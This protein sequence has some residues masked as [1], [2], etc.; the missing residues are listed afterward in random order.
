MGK[1][2]YIVELP[3]VGVNVANYGDMPRCGWTV[4][5]SPRRAVRNFLRRSNGHTAEIVYGQ[6]EAM[7]GGAE[8]RA[9]LVPEVDTSGM[10]ENQA[11]R[12]VENAF[13]QSLAPA[14][15]DPS[16]Y[17]GRAKELIRKAGAER[18]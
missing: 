3:D 8:S 16:R 17:L 13:A 1:D 15:T 12:F 9:F 14:G 7:N 6:L 11:R 18:R 2:R 4:A 10:D 5:E